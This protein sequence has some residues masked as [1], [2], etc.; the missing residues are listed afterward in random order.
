MAKDEYLQLSNKRQDSKS[1]NQVAETLF[2]DLVK[3]AREKMEARQVELASFTSENQGLLP[4]NFQA[5]AMA[6]N[7]KQ[8]ETALLSLR[9][10]SEKQRQTLLESDLNNNKNMQEQLESQSVRLVRQNQAR[11][12]VN[13]AGK[14][15]L[16][17]AGSLTAAGLTP[18]Q[19]AA[20]IGPETSVRIAS[21]SSQPVTVLVPLGSEGPFH[22][23]GQVTANGKIV[24]SFE[25]AASGQPA[26][27]KWI[28]L[29]EGQ[30]HL[31]VTVK[32]QT[33]GAT[34][35]SELDFRV[36]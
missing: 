12:T 7:S 30:Y 29:R 6:V 36:N 32:N 22:V 15:A 35:N 9:I 33:S 2:D 26:M 4:D 27:A 1:G 23:Y 19:L 5:N 28:Q 21:S 17:N 25:E 8:Q 11:V 18:A 31:K 14:I 24:Q 13:D 20:A 10:A 34:H 16:E 3:Q